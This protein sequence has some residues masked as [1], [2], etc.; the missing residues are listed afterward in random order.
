MRKA[1]SS[2]DIQDKRESISRVVSESVVE[3]FN[4][5]FG[6]NV[7]PGAA[8]AKFEGHTGSVYSSIKLHQGDVHIEFCF[9]FDFQLLFNAASLIFTPEYLEKSPV[10]Q[11]IALEI[12]NIVCSKVKAYL[13]DSG[14]DTE[15]GFPYVPQHEKNPLLKHDNTVH[16][17]F[18][19]NDGNKQEGLGVVANFFTDAAH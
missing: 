13:N 11:D 17:H 4:T 2:K 8:A 5:M 18:S 14:F 6:Q 12:A 10:H 16:M 19:Y 7:T 1:I 15:M 9:H 3:T